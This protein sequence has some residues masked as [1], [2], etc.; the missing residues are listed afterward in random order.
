MLSRK[1]RSHGGKGHD[2]VGKPTKIRGEK[3]AEEKKK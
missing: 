2:Q 1:R 3:K